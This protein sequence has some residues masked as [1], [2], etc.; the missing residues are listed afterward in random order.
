[1]PERTRTFR[2]TSLWSSS[3]LAL[4]TA[5]LFS[6]QVEASQAN[7]I[8][9]PDAV[10]RTN[11]LSSAPIASG[12]PELD[13]APA[14]SLTDV[15]ETTV[16]SE[17]LRPKNAPPDPS[18]GTSA[19]YAD[20]NAA[21]VAAD[22]QAAP[23]S[24]Q[25][26]A[27][28]DVPLLLNG[29]F[30]GMISV[31]VD[32]QG[33]GLIDVERLIALLEPVVT[34]ETLAQL[35][36]VSA[37]RPRVPFDTFKAQSLSLTF[38]SSTLELNAAIQGE[39]LNPTE[40]KLS[41]VRTIPDPASFP[42]PSLFSAGANIS[43]AQRY[44]HDLNDIA[45]VR[46]AVDALVHWGGFTGLTLISGAE[47]DG[48]REGSGWQ[49]TETRLVK[50]FYGPA[51][52]AMA[53]EFT[54][55]ADGFQGSGRLVGIGIERAYS[56][57]RPFQNIRPSG[58]QEFSLERE[59]DVDVI[60]NGLKTQTLRLRPGRYSISDF[61][62]AT[63]S[64]QVQLVV[65]DLTGRNE[66]AVFDIFAGADLLGE[67]LVDFGFAAGRYEGSAPYEYDGPMLATGFVRKGWTDSLTVGANAQV[68]SDVQQ[69]GGMSVWGSRF[70]LLLLELA[71]SRNR[72]LGQ[73]GAAASISY[74]HT[75]SLRQ[76][77]D[78]RV[79]ANF[80]AYS[81]H[82][83]DVFQ[84]RRSNPDAWRTSLLVQW[85][86]PWELGLSVGVGVSERRLDARR[87]RQIDLGVSRS[88][89]R[90]SLVS[91]VSFTNDEEQ[92][93]VR[94][95]VGLS[96]P[97]GPRWNAQAR[98]DSVDNLSEVVLARYST[99]ALNDLS[100]EVRFSNNDRARDISGRLDYVNNRFEA[101]FNHNRRYDRL[102]NGDPGVE[103]SLALRSF[104]GFSGGA[105]GIGRPVDDAFIIAPVHE[106][107][108]AS[109]VTLVSG[110]RAV[111]RSGLFGPP[112]I[113]IQRSYG[114]NSFDILVEP[115]PTGY[116]L[117]SAT[118]SVFPP[119]GAGYRQ[120]IGSDA[121]R[122]AIGVLASPE[123]PYVLAIGSVLA[124][125][126]PSDQARP[127]FTNRA[128]RFVADQLA[129]GR[130]WIFI[131]DRK[132]AEFVIH[133]NSEGIVNVGTITTTGR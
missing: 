111:A 61:P 10:I 99:G 28:I 113:P 48:A 131:Q 71:A 65:D 73:D 17:R 83:S 43:L 39:G 118:L 36:T 30:L 93:E 26:Y 100:G 119:F 96:V 60:I 81:E 8:S 56:V 24:A 74:R 85:Q 3:P 80:S 4:L 37:G 121:S 86:A 82:F 107:L 79:T 63:G 45:P 70:G 2:R 98:Y 25:V 9:D 59:A 103:S 104:V 130:Y 52:R 50:D 109:R 110:T 38:S 87:T 31:D 132:V 97:L 91:N 112:V 15:P 117:G 55:S 1:M 51:I 19:R 34:P 29:R 127:F 133:E 123:G 90:F 46:G 129:P 115:L 27:P 53:G 41:G 84:P 116:D 120:Q 7:E 57:V 78:L 67:G 42:Q 102:L 76:Q 126:A 35:R 69:I 44:I 21:I 88:F 20:Q 58:R 68:S 5:L 14:S 75:L 22:I 101:Q 13:P 122:I 89:G 92:D 54:P 94:F 114:I 95:A 125:G 32:L 16:G 33:D 18:S 128:G 6:G 124:E 12:E 62:F 105:F 64:N 11:R 106:S 77:D 108:K 49:R 47:Y 40:M 72:L 66:I 23:R